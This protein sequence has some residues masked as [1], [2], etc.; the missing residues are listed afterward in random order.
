MPPRT[1]KPA[2]ITMRSAAEA[3][4][5]PEAL[6]LSLAIGGATR[7]AGSEE[8]TVELEYEV[9]GREL[10]FTVPGCARFLA[11][12]PVGDFVGAADVERR[13]GV[14]RSDVSTLIYTG[15]ASDDGTIVRLPYWA[16]GTAAYFAGADVE[17]FAI[18]YRAWAERRALR[19]KPAG[20]RPAAKP[21]DGEPR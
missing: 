19:Q 7:R 11:R 21:A 16:V 20:R 2:P 1:T 3:L 15:I 8:P 4:G 9:S 6:V 14:R 5:V 10:T 18:H 12:C 17:A 13:L